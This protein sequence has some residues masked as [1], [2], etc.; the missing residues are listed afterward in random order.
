MWCII[1]CEWPGRVLAKTSKIC[2]VEH[3]PLMWQMHAGLITIV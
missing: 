1:E 3:L 2:C